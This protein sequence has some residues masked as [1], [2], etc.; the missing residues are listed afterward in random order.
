[1]PEQKNPEFDPH[2]EI[3]PQIINPDTKKEVLL[4]LGYGLIFLVGMLISIVGI[5]FAIFNRLIGD[6]IWIAGTAAI[7]F[8]LIKNIKSTIGKGF[9]IANIVAKIITLVLSLIFII[10]ANLNSMH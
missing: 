5:F 3:D 6:I 10:I 9:R 8:M 7:V 4:G 2:T 1:M